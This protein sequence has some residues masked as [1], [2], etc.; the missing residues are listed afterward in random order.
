MSSDDNTQRL[1]GE[2]H[3]I[4]S[5]LRD[6]QIQ[7]NQRLDRM[8]DRLRAV[9]Q[10]AAAVGAVSGGVMAVGIALITETLK[11]WIGKGTPHP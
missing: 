4:V 1:I 8:D 7:T 5:S 10:R 3:G 11:T 9:E 2:I 6:G